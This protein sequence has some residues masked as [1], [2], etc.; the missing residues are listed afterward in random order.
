MYTLADMASSGIATDGFICYHVSYH[1]L[2]WTMRPVVCLYKSVY[3]QRGSPRGN[4]RRDLRRS[5]DVGAFPG[6]GFVA[7]G[8]PK[9]FNLQAIRLHR[10]YTLI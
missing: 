1:H 7:S 6:A 4:R 8:L 9:T 10:L 3:F 2:P 5:L